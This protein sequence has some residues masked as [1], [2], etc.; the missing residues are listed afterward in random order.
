VGRAGGDDCGDSSGESALPSGGERGDGDTEAVVVAVET[1]RSGEGNRGTDDA[2]GC[3]ER[4]VDA[5]RGTVD[6]EVAWAGEAGRTGVA[7][8]DDRGDDGGAG[9]GDAHSDGC[10]KSAA[11]KLL[12]GLSAPGPAVSRG[13][14]R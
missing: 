9:G 14:G 5:P 11:L 12:A 6:G 2:V 4:A 3:S 8:R 10:S 7:E 1:G 13:S